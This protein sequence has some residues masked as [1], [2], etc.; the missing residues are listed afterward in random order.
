MSE[1]LAGPEPAAARPTQIGSWRPKPR[2]LLIRGLAGVLAVIVVAIIVGLASDSSSPQGA[3]RVVPADALG[4]VDVSL[5]SRRGAVS[6]VLTMARRLPDFGHFSADVEARIGA[7]LSGGRPVDLA[8]QILPWAGHEAALALL[9]TTTATAGSL[10]VLDVRDRRRALAFIRNEG[11]VGAGTYRGA[12]LYAYRSGSE[13]SFVSHFLLAGQDASVKAAI[14]VASGVLPS[15]AAS[16]V[17]QR[18]MGPEPSGR[19]LSAYASLAGVR[20]LLS[21]RGGVVGAFGDLLY[22]PALQGVAL[23]LEPTSG[24]ARVLIHS[25]LD[26]TLQRLAPGQSSFTPTLQNVLPSGAILMLDVRGLNRIAPAVLSAGATAGIAGGVRQ[27][28]SRLG[29][30]LGAEGVNVH[31][32]TSLFSGETAVGIVPNGQ[33]NTLVVVSRVPNV[34]QA[35]TQLADLEIPLAQLFQ[36]PNPTKVPVFNDV[37]VGGVSDH[38]LSLASGPELDYAVFRGLVVISTSTAG[39]AA[40]AQHAHSLA[41][42]P[43]FR[44]VL[45]T[46][47]TGVS[48]L[49]YASLPDLVALGRST[50]L[51]SGPGFGRLAPDLAAI[52]HAGLISTRSSG[53]STVRLFLSLP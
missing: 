21:P 18:A 10:I 24:G 42:D 48:S 19:V 31:A 49:I 33:S 35:R 2:R 36:P 43:G 8:T 16:T 27:L 12:S 3:S 45:E 4:F 25:A 30:A 20:R 26:P 6:D 13:L 34:A 41:Q 22:Q 46:H 52:A 23:G 11:A 29:A 17:Y 44:S 5:D 53:Q 39:V 51:I 28:L 32:I 14:D 47:P 15:L 1:A 7:I 50:N 9:N 40:V 38:Q 37:T